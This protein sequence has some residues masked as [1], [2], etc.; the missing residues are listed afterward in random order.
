MR[1]DARMKRW[2]KDIAFRVRASTAA[3]VARCPECASEDVEKYPRKGDHNAFD[4]RCI[5]CNR[6]FMWRY[7]IEPEAQGVPVPVRRR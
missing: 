5:K 4:V 7:E 2:K 1:Y 6:C 3:R